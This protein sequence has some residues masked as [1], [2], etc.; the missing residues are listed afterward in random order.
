MLSIALPPFLAHDFQKN[1]I[2]RLQRSDFPRRGLPPGKPH[3]GIDIGISDR[4][5]TEA[6]GRP[7][8]I[9]L[10]KPP[11]EIDAAL[12]ERRPGKIS[13]DLGDLIGVPL[14]TEQALKM[15]PV[16]N[17]IFVGPG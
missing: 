5:H 1:S 12:G 9:Q 3:P 10:A 17:A 7:R 13:L 15:I 16:G 2:Q 14:A 11:P 6:A 4:C 8:V